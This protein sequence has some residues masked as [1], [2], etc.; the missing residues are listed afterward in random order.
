MNQH[1]TPKQEFYLKNLGIM[2]ILAISLSLTFMM[3][4][5]YTI[6]NGVFLL[7]VIIGVGHIDRAWTTNYP[8][9]QS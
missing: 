1:L 4:F 8:Q 9:S 6:L 5:D 2:L 3:V 7:L